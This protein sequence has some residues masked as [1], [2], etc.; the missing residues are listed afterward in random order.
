M[1]FTSIIAGLWLAWLLY[2]LASAFGNK[3]TVRRR[4][5]FWRTGAISVALVLFL[6]HA[7]SPDL[8]RLR[9]LP[10]TT[11]LGLAGVVVCAAGLGFSV[12]ARI[13]LGRNWSAAPSVKEG[14][15]LIRGGPYRI[16][17]H[18]IYTGILAAAV[19][20]F[21]AGG[22]VM[23]AVIPAALFVVFIVK[24]RIEES[25]MMEQFPGEYPEYRR[26][27]RA[28]IPFLF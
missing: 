12:W 23:D 10:A 11:A 22:R 25:L 17:R 20:T 2:W 13:F 1:R 14:H 8:P 18:P 24:L 15:E 26:R 4:G 19:G 21:L 3:R 27:T 6:M 28:L 5:A 16:V 9:I 7:V